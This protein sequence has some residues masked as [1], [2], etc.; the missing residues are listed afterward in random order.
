MSLLVD[1]VDAV[2][3]VTTED[4]LRALRALL[5][6]IQR[7]GVGLEGEQEGCLLRVERHGAEAGGGGQTMS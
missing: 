7:A 1:E 3:R 4:G 5:S 6:R 2:L